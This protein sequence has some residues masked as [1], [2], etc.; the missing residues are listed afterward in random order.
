MIPLV[1]H[2][3]VC[4]S[5]S[6]FAPLSGNPQWKRQKPRAMADVTGTTENNSHGF[7][8]RATG[9]A[10]KLY[11]TPASSPHSSGR[12]EAIP[13]FPCIQNQE[14]SWLIKEKFIQMLAV[15]AL[16]F[17]TPSPSGEANLPSL[18][19]RLG[20]AVTINLGAQEHG[21]EDTMLGASPACPVQVICDLSAV[22]LMQLIVADGAIGLK[23]IQNKTGISH[24]DRLV[25][26][27]E[28]WVSCLQS[29]LSTSHW[30]CT[31]KGRA[32][33]GGGKEMR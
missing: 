30:K 14:P 24:W 11:P 7:I 15:I 33:E 31:S 22:I 28:P 18:L 9:C 32:S 13:H 26:P 23:I 5:L 6:Y 3:L 4:C 2:S 17:L 21:A 29:Q 27:T 10:Y 25:K 19:I 20:S 16:S 1:L 8:E 12:W